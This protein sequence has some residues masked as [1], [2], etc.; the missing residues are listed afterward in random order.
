MNKA[1]SLDRLRAWAKGQ[2]GSQE[3]QLPDISAGAA[4]VIHGSLTRTYLEEHRLRVASVRDGLMRNW[5]PEPIAVFAAEEAKRAFRSALL[6]V[7]I[8]GAL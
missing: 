8:K 3:Y 7:G 6:A 5:W 4:A 2:I 1:E